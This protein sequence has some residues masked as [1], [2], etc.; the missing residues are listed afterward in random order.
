MLIVIRVKISLWETG[1][2]KMKQEK[3]RKTPVFQFE[4]VGEWMGGEREGRREGKGKKE[5]YMFPISVH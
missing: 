1:D 3:I 4:L 5:I 2:T